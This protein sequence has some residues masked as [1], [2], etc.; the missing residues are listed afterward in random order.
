[1][2][3]MKI[4]TSTLTRLHK[5]YKYYQAEAEKEHAR[6]EAMKTAGSDAHDLKQAVCFWRAACLLMRGD[7]HHGETDTLDSWVSYPV[8]ADHNCAVQENVLAESSM[9]VPETRQRLE[10]ALADLQSYVV[11]GHQNRAAPY[12][13]QEGEE[14]QAATER[15]VGTCGI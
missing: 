3:S 6:V 9:M 15:P 12:H 8:V 11:S 2:R 1:M 13:M 10:A 14:Q 4:K 5:E 7:L